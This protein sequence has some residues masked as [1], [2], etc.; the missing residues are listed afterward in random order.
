MDLISTILTAGIT[1]GCVTA[2]LNW[3]IKTQEL[4]D[5]RRWEIKR[6]ACLEALEIIDARFADYGWKSNGA[7][8]KVD[9]QDIIKTEKIRSCF[10][11]LVLACINSKVPQSFEKCLHLKIENT[12]P[13]PLTMDSV[14]ELRNAIRK[15]L[16][17]GKDL[18]TK[19]SWITYIDWIRHKNKDSS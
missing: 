18:S 19:I 9:K 7:P 3:Y 1:S 13:K 15:E 14:V 5:Q 16:G 8:L 12:D 6:E 2:I 17:F 4:G 11:R 10:N